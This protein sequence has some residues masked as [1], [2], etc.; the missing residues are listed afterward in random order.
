MGYNQAHQVALDFY[1][2]S[3]FSIYHPDVI[4]MKP[5]YWNNGWL[6]FW[7]IRR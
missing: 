4:K 1:E 7:G 3:N 6:N 5:G 2:V